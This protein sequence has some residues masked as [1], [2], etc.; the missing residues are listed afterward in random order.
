MFFKSLFLGSLF[1]LF[2]S[3]SSFA[4]SNTVIVD[5]LKNNLDVSVSEI[6]PHIVEYNGNF[7]NMDK[8]NKPLLDWSF[9]SNGDL[10]YTINKLGPG[11][12]FDEFSME[13][14]DNISLLKDQQFNQMYFDESGKYVN[15]GIDYDKSFYDEFKEL[16]ENGLTF[17]NQ[18]EQEIM[19][20]IEQYLVGYRILD[21]STYLKF[22]KYGDF[23]K[24][25]INNS[26]K[27]NQ[28]E[29]RKRVVNTYGPLIGDNDYEKLYDA[30]F[31]VYNLNYNYAYKG[32]SL[33]KVLDTNNGVCY[34]YATI[35]KILLENEGLEVEPVI[36]YMDGDRSETH[37]IIRTKI[38]GRWVYS[39][40]TNV[41][42]LG[43]YKVMIPYDELVKVY[44]PVHYT[45][46]DW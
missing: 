5:I 17:I 41:K 44:Q 42:D 43:I 14:L 12:N 7:V 26:E 40:P 2:V 11:Y 30:C 24:V 29:L 16:E 15:P 36:C 28:D 19:D 39:D 1:S 8:D 32:K 38:D 6:S 20:F 23:Y 25:Y 3:F 37:V 46:I 45:A 34:H 27:Y 9:D 31:K 18:D 21:D 33:D 35:V 13:D 22:D 4:S 10:Y